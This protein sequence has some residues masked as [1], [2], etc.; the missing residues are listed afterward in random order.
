MTRGSARSS[1]TTEERF[2][3]KVQKTDGCWFWVG[4]DR[5]D[6]GYGR[7]NTTNFYGAKK[8]VRVHRYS[9]FLAYSKWPSQ[10]IDHL[11]RE[12]LCVRPDHLEDVDI[13]ENLARGRKARGSASA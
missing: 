12:K 3:R 2:W 6:K 11:C 5:T 8:Q 13:A 1:L 10:T 7:W 4:Q 9:Y